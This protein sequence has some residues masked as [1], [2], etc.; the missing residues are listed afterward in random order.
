MK[1]KWEKLPNRLNAFTVRS[2]MMADLETGDII[3]HYSSNTRI[4]LTEKCVTETGTYYRTASASRQGLNWAFE[5]TAFGL[6]ND[7]APSALPTPPDS[8][9]R[10]AI[11]LNG[12]NKT[13][14]IIQ[15]SSTPKGGEEKGRKKLWERLFNK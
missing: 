13:Q 11:A 3:Q 4:T 12:D 15:N 1:Y 7:I 9:S 6:P 5:A 14:K 8:F 10:V 2:A